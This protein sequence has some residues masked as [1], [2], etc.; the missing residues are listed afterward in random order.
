MPEDL[1]ETLQ[2]MLSRFNI[3]SKESIIRQY[4]HEVQGGSVVKPLVGK[5]NDGPSDA[6]V[7][8]PVLDTYEGVVVSNGICPRYSDIDTYHMMAC[9][10]DEAIRNVVAVGGDPDRI[11]G[12][13][14]FCWPDPIQ[15]EKT[16]DGEYK[17]A[18]LVRACR[19]VYDYT[20]A[21]GVPCISGKDSM[22]N[23][24]K[25]G[26]Y[27]ISIPPTLLFSALGKIKDVT[28]A[29]TSDVKEAGD[30]VYVLGLT[31]A[32]L[33]GSAYYRLYGGVGNSVPKVEADTAMKLYRALAKAMEK[34]LVRS[35]HDCSDGGLA[36]AL[37]ESAFAGGL[38]MKVDMR[39][40][41]AVGCDR[42]DFLLFSE[43]QSRFVVTVR[44][45][46]AD[47]F[48]NT[49]QGN[50]FSKIGELTSEP[51]LL[52]SG[53]SGKP[54]IKADIYQLKEAWQRPLRDVV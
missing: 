3:C 31:R 53:L 32:E 50:S 51:I 35:C 15:S 41:P 1:T 52:V 5:E 44:S 48:E 27:Q 40:V 19:A 25:I 24:Y 34:R 28:K 43:S 22:K 37:A 47:K 13:D 49:L 6:A 14:N 2:G 16:P 46:D 4:D 7:I 42:D 17:L 23:D 8:R 9:A 54:V 20:T 12:L 11:A 36:V 29:V 26:K 38:G 18:Q 45:D 33:G 21:F 10:I 39:N 30:I